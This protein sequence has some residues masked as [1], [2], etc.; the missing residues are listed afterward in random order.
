MYFVVIFWSITETFSI[1][2]DISNSDY[3]F[4]EFSYYIIDLEF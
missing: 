2:S 1:I 3:V 4:R